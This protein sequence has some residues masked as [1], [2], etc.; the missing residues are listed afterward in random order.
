LIQIIKIFWV[1]VI[2]FDNE[3]SWKHYDFI[4]LSNFHCLLIEIVVILII[5]FV[6]YFYIALLNEIFRLSIVKNWYFCFFNM[7]NSKKYWDICI[8]RIFIF[9]IIWLIILWQLQVVIINQRIENVILQPIGFKWMRFYQLLI[10]KTQIWLVWINIWYKT[11]HVLQFKIFYWC[12]II[13]FIFILFI[14]DRILKL[15]LIKIWLI[16]YILLKSLFIL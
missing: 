10:L 14:I 6:I 13:F 11:L 4:F 8:I 16:I 15:I 3:I 7:K 9:R 12:I 1:I 2:I 5:S